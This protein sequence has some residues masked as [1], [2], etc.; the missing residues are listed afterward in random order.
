MVE[1]SKPHQIDRALLNTDGGSRG[2]PGVSGIGFIIS[3]DDGRGL[4][5]V[6]KGGAY[7]GVATNNQAEYQAL[8]WGLRNAIDLGVC[9][10]DIHS[11]S[12]LV[13]KQLQ[14]EYKVKNEA[15]KPFHMQACALLGRFE[16]YTLNHVVREDNTAADTLANEAMDE[17]GVVGAPRVLYESG[18][19]FDLAAGDEAESLPGSSLPDQKKGS[20]LYTLTVKD[21]F[22]AAH[23]LIGYPGKC[24]NLHGHTW[25]IEV[26]V[27]GTELDDIGIIYD[28]KDLKDNLRV[29]L[30]AYDHENLNEVPPFDEINATAENLA[31]VIYERLE[32]T[33]PSHVKLKEVAVWESP[34]ARL[35]YTRI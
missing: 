20:S 28:F 10:L 26:S 6:C 19:L 21:H 24:K 31:Q 35:S 16:S 4:E 32:D 8:I 23:A 14:G 29:I 15:I 3:V 11:D 33:L 2:N 5:V 25:D 12:E 9:V 7:I 34:I 27:C 22:D 17:R 30:E 1:V 18:E 13:I